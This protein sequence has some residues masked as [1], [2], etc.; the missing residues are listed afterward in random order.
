MNT[1]KPFDARNSVVAVI[2]TILFSAT[3]VLSAVGPGIANAA[4]ADRQIAEA[5]VRPL[6]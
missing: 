6:A 1:Y 3:C 2:C 4:P 5:S